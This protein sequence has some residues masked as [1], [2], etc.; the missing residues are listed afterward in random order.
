MVKRKTVSLFLSL[1]QTL[2]VLESLP[3]LYAITLLY[4]PVKWCSAPP[5]RFSARFSAAVGLSPSLHPELQHCCRIFP[6]PQLCLF[7]PSRVFLRCWPPDFSLLSMRGTADPSAHQSQQHA[8]RRRTRS[9]SRTLKQQRGASDSRFTGAAVSGES[10]TEYMQWCFFFWGAR[11][12]SALDC[13]CAICFQST[14]CSLLHTEGKLMCV[15][16]DAESTQMPIRA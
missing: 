9:L 4:N 1:L 6:P 2:D 14:H 10:L 13:R 7:F 11:V 15:G 3:F 8:R 16:F 12:C 5:P